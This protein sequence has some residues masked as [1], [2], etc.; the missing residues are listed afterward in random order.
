MGE[1][2]G[3]VIMIA[4]LA[5]GLFTL[6]YFS[7]RGMRE[8]KVEK[9][10]QRAPFPSSRGPSE[11][12]SVVE[13]SR[14]REPYAEGL[15]QSYTA[16]E[17]TEL[18][19]GLSPALTAARKGL[20]DLRRMSDQYA[21]TWRIDWRKFAALKSATDTATN[22]AEIFSDILRSLIFRDD[23]AHEK[24]E[25]IINKLEAISYDVDSCVFD[26]ENV[27]DEIFLE[28]QRKIDRHRLLKFDRS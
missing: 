13:T 19:A 27:R 2:A 14:S 9:P 6:R 7:L 22:Q 20:H 15:F 28:R 11:A 5:A 16:A 17:V 23:A 10:F 4:M 1:V 8:P 18:F 12:A 21:E 3:A 26:L 24:Y 25:E